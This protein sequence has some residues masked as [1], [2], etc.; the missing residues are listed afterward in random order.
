LK[1]RET[2]LGL[3]LLTIE[4]SGNL[5]MTRELVREKRVAFPVLLDSDF[6]SRE[7]LHIPG[8]PTTFIV[9]GDGRIRSR[10]IGYISDLEG[11]V[12]SVI[13]NL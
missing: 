3:K 5:K 7:V 12:E 9:D 13:E 1:K 11:V 6:Y 10:L 2:E 8:T 4:I